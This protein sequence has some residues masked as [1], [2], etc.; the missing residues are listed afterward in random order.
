M[1]RRYGY[2]Y[3]CAHP[4]QGQ[5]R[6]VLSGRLGNPAD[7]ESEVCQLK[8][9]PFRGAPCSDAAGQQLCFKDVMRLL[10]ET[11]SQAQWDA[12]QQAPFF[13]FEDSSAPGKFH[14]LKHHI[15]QVQH[16]SSFSQGLPKVQC[17]SSPPHSSC[18]VAT[19]LPNAPTQSSLLPTS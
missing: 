9:V 4:L 17:A 5:V 8:P 12:T 7:G 1:G 3:P 13:S 19:I 16:L 14:L 11:G 10:Q 2:R 6:K 15:P 18:H